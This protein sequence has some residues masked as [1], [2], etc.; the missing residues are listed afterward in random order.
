MYDKDTIKLL[1]RFSQIPI[2]V[3]DRKWKEQESYTSIHKEP[4]AFEN[5]KLAELKKELEKKKFCFL[6]YDSDVPVAI[7]GSLGAEEYY[8][9][10][11]VAYGRTDTFD[12]R[13]FMWK[14]KIRECP[15]C[16][17]EDL[18]SLA[19]YFA[20]KEVSDRPEPKAEKEKQDQITR[21]E[22]R[23][24]DS[25]QKN[26]TYMEEVAWYD[27][28]RNGDVEYMEKQAFYSVTSHPILMENLKKNEEYITAISISLAARAAIES[29]LSSAEGFINNDIYL[30]KLAQCKTLFEIKRLRR[31]SQIYFARLVAQHK[32]N[33]TLNFYVEESKKCVLANRFDR[34][35]I[36]K[37]AD[38]LGISKEYL[39][40]VFKKYEGIPITEYISGIKIE[41]ACNMLKYS[42]K[43]I[44]EIAD[45]L[46]YGSVSHFSTAFR[47][48]MKQSPKEYRTQHRKTTF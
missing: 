31:E 14:H 15:N 12:C 10:G 27:H 46:H 6:P 30:K 23:Q 29:G 24:I 9:L 13:N 45:Y 16:Q 40:K 7:C 33:N 19:S 41:A 8:I 25:F 44:Q 2:T 37:I 36:Q 17:L 22:L 5:G 48:K 35:S 18:F 1:F 26:H 42:D 47:K 34:I 4:A 39:Q 11:P 28:I 3:Y 43:K 21:E 20:G 32:K 38:N